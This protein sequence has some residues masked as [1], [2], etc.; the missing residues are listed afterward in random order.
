MNNASL[1]HAPAPN[2]LLPGVVQA[3]ASR[4][5][6]WLCMFVVVFA[7]LASR[8]GADATWDFRNYHLYIGEAVLGTRS[9]LDIAVAQQQTYFNP[10]LDIIHAWLRR[11]L[12]GSPGLLLAAMGVP[13]GIAAFL[14]WRIAAAVIPCGTSYRKA[15]ATLAVLFGATGAAGL[16]T[17]GTTM[18]EMIPACFMLGG[19]LILVERQPGARW[20]LAFAGALFG[21]AVGFKLVIAPTSI[22][23]A[24]ALL[25]TPGR[26]LRV[27]AREIVLFGMGAAI[28]FLLV[29]G[30]WWLHLYQSYGNPMFPF[31]NNLFRSPWVPPDRMTDDRFKPV[32]WLRALFYPF[33]WGVRGQTLVTEVWARD[34][35]F[36]M[37]YAAIAGLA[38]IAALRHLAPANALSP[39]NARATFLAIF[40]AVSFVGWEAMFSILRYLAPIEL[41][42]GV[43]VVVPFLLLAPWLRVKLAPHA[44]LAGL[45]IMAAAW[46]VYPEWGHNAGL[47]S[48]AHIVLPPLQDSSLVI[49]LDGAPLGYLATFASSTVQFVGANN[50]VVTPGQTTLLARQVET[51]IR[52]HTGPLWGIEDSRDPTKGVANTTLAYYGLS[53]GNE[54]VQVLS[55]LDN[56]AARLC[57]LAPLVGTRTQ[58]TP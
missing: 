11:A 26:T 28:G 46:T 23:A 36:A 16:P 33:Y 48:A 3:L 14:T 56:D 20:R 58:R 39:A 43:I 10:A 21:I 5:W 57:P 18:S 40:F 8:R 51:A 32:G 49:L 4:N 50:S 24:A 29:G 42:T 44:A 19:L 30:P 55:S 6:H 7:V 13:Q 2:G 37:A 25:L 34:P 52:M 1:R 54:C 15:L 38:G 12:Y 41:L 45:F 22:G 27:R 9:A 17:L 35:R 47:N 53:R 31:Y